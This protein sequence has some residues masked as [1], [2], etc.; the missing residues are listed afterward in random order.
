MTT[1][2]LSAPTTDISTVDASTTDRPQPTIPSKRTAPSS[3]TVCA[4]ENDRTRES[5]GTGS[6]APD[7][8]SLR[9]TDGKTT[10]RPHS[11]GSG[12]D[13]ADAGGHDDGPCND[14]PIT[15]DPVTAADTRHIAV[16]MVRAYRSPARLGKLG[17]EYTAA[18]LVR[19]G[20]R[21]IEHNYRTR[22][23][24]IDLL[25]LTPAGLLAVVEVKTR[26][27][28]V[29]GL[30]VQAVTPAK[31]HRLR[32]AARQ[33]LIEHPAGG[34]PMRFDVASIIVRAGRVLLDYREGAF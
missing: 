2:T 5:T 27:S 13:H 23:G 25:A 22:Y 20:W 3:A 26:S 14:R 18:I 21:I 29:T 30:P 4:G 8:G 33:W 31:Q 15:E 16:Q 7:G 12:A 11:H 19:H 1:A 28:L 32:L 34:R 10:S 24:E 9:Q 17:E 6:L